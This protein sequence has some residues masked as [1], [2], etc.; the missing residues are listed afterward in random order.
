MAEEP[1]GRTAVEDALVRA[2]A[3]L[4]V[5]RGPRN[6]GVRD[7]AR[8]AGVNHGQVH[9]YFGCKDT[10]IRAAMRYL[11]EEHLAHATARAG[12][13]AVPP[14]LSLSEDSQYWRAVFRSV[15]DGELDFARVELAE[16][17]SVPHRAL[18]ALAD[19]RGLD[20]PDTVLKAQVATS[21]ALQLAWAVL[22]DFVFTVTDVGPDERDAVREH[23]ARVAASGTE[24]SP[25]AV[26]RG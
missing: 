6:A 26:T 21:V 13:G 15:L 7:I 4:L 19:Q 17:L 11:A 10:L 22:E 25:R 14:P 1:R 12:G 16:D 2:A 20:E 5:E 18:L 24:R 9:H 8:R 3:E 23:V